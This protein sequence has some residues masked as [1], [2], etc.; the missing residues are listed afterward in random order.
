MRSRPM[1]T[2]RLETYTSVCLSSVAYILACRCMRAP[3]VRSLARSIMDA[4]SSSSAAAA[5]PTSW[6]V[7][8]DEAGNATCNWMVLS[9]YFGSTLLFF[10][11]LC[12]MYLY[13]RIRALTRTNVPRSQ[14]Q[15]PPPQKQ[16]QQQQPQ[17]PQLLPPPPQAAKRTDRR[18]PD[19]SPVIARHGIPISDMRLPF[20]HEQQHPLYARGFRVGE[21][22]SM[23]ISPRTLN[24]RS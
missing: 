21:D 2:C 19:I 6:L 11:C 22:G 3:F 13:F 4:S 18:L 16:Q 9:L 12:A 7:L 20:Q 10:V 23:M 5:A 15:S 8:R 24:Y 17:Q 14:Q 1:N